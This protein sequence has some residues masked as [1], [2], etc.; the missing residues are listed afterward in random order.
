MT[1]LAFLVIFWVLI[2]V[3]K[4]LWDDLEMKESVKKRL[5][6]KIEGED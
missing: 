6:H 4:M 2:M 3:K 1:V 5:K